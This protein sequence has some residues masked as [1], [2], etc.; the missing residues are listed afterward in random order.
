MS[1]PTSI[2]SV[3]DGPTKPGPRPY[4]HSQSFLLLDPNSKA[5]K[6]FRGHFS[7]L[8]PSFYRDKTEAQDLMRFKI[9]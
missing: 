6:D 3:A 7:T 5:R 1:F 8:G 2:L 9:S 4:S